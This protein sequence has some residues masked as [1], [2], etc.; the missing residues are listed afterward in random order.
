MARQQSKQQQLHIIQTVDRL[1]YEKGFNVMSFKDIAEA[2]QL[3]K[4]NLYYYFKTKDEL[5]KAVI[6]Y[7]LENMRAMLQQWEEEFPSALDR[8]QRYVQIM[9]N[10]ARQV[11]HYGCPMGSL[12]TELAKGQQDLQVISRSQFDLFKSWLKKQFK[13]LL[14]AENA[15]HYALRLMARTQGVVVMAQ[16]YQDKKFIKREADEIKQWLESLAD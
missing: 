5:L 8:L 10:E 11:V 4:G 2:C 7:R 3:S 1:I 16:A 6:D 14:P 15:E 12:N 13:I 9:I